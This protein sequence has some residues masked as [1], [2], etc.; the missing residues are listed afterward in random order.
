MD[1][2]VKVSTF[3]TQNLSTWGGLEPQTFGF[4]LHKCASHIYGG[5]QINMS[6]PVDKV[7]EARTWLWPPVMK[8]YFACPFRVTIFY[9]KN[10]KL[11]WYSARDL[12]LSSYIILSRVAHFYTRS[13]KWF[14]FTHFTK[15]VYN[16]CAL[17]EFRATRYQIN[18]A[19]SGLKM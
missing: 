14:P 2:F 12:F 9:C 3:L 18:L 8:I 1:V 6:R 15:P 10:I 17:Y 16:H 19:L 13:H 5:A 4:M 7:T 11:K